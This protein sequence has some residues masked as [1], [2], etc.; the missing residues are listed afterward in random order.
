FQ[1]SIE[2]Q[3]TER[4]HLEL[5]HL[6][7][8]GLQLDPTVCN[9]DLELLLADTPTPDGTPGGLDAAFVY[10]TDLF[11]AGTVTT[12]ADRFVH[13]LDT[14]TVDPHR[15]VGDVDLITAGEAR[16]LVPAVGP[17]GVGTGTWPELIDTA[18]AAAPETSAI[19]DRSRTVTYRDLDTAANRLAR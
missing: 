16:A 17:T 11:D 12:F 3:N 5:P 4:P 8:T 1:V 14:V 7:V 19:V 13:L 9:F 6:T 18:V 15:P 2:Y 10:A